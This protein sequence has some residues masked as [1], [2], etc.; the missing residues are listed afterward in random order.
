[1]NQ[2]PGFWE[3]IRSRNIRPLNPLQLTIILSWVILQGAALAQSVDNFMPRDAANCDIRLPPADAGLIASPGG[4]VVIYPRNAALTPGYTGCKR[5][6]I[7]GPGERFSTFATLYFKGGQLAVAAS[8]DFRNDPEKLE[9]VC[10]LPAGKSLLPDSGRRYTDKA[11]AGIASE[12]LYSLMTPS[13][14]RLCA[15]ESTNKVCQ[16]EP[17]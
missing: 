7:A 3:P 13:W 12:G 4:F 14:P 8:H 17:N 16:E 10:A 1:M 15:K 2:P 9:G 6:W 11:C 5:L